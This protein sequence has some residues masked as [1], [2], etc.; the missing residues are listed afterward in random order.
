[1]SKLQDYEDAL[2]RLLEGRPIRVPQGTK[3]SN[4]AVALEAGRTKGS[5]KK[6]RSSFSSLITK[7]ADAAKKQ[8][9]PHTTVEVPAEDTE[10]APKYY[11]R[12]YKESLARE[13]SLIY[14]VFQL[15]EKVAKLETLKSPTK[16]SSKR[17]GKY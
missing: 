6:S 1:M 17:G 16:L 15:K 14:E 7:I 5:I 11:Q 4:D 10:P 8:R 2:T 9:E 13:V 3:I 12:L